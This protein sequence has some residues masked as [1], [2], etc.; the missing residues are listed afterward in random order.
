MKENDKLV[1]FG[2]YFEWQSSK[3]EEHLAIHKITL[4]EAAEVFFFRR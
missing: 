3:A 2:D 1:F 4:E